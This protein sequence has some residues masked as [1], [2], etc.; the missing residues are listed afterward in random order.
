MTNHHPFLNVFCVWHPGCETADRLVNALY[1]SVSRDVENPV[2]RG[3][4]VPVYFRSHPA[5]SHHGLPLPVDVETAR[6]TAVVMFVDDQ[7]LDAADPIP[8]QP[9]TGWGTYAADLLARCQAGAPAGTHRVYPVSLTANAF[10]LHPAL[11]REN[12]LRLHPYLAD[13][14]LPAR[15]LR[16]V[17]HALC[18]QLD[19]TALGAGRDGDALSPEPVQLFLS[20]AKQD[21]APLAGQLQAWLHANTGL[22]DFFD[23]RDIAT[24]YDFA[25]EIM[26]QIRRSALLAVQTDAYATRTWCRTEV[27]LA[28]RY[29]VPL[30]VVN[31][32]ERGEGRSFPY[33]GNVPTARLRDG[34]DFGEVVLLMLQEV[35]RFRYLR[36]H[37]D[38]LRV[39][40]HLP[41]EAKVFYRAPELLSLV[42]LLA[43]ARQ[44]AAADSQTD[45]PDGKPASLI[46]YSDPPL[47]SEEF[48]L[49]SS[50]VPGTLITT[51]TNLARHGEAGFRPE[52]FK[53]KVIALSISDSPDLLRLGFGKMHLTDAMVEIA[54]YLL[55]R[56][57]TLAYGGDLRP[58]GFTDLLLQL[59]EGYE[60]EAADATAPP[61]TVLPSPRARN[62]LAWPLYVPM[63]PAEK[64]AYRGMVELRPVPPPENVRAALGLDP[65]AFLPPNTP[66]TR[67][68]WACCLTEMRRA[69]TLQVDARIVLGGQVTGFKGKYPGVAEEALMALDAGQPIYLLGAFGGAARAIADALE[70]RDPEA[71]TQA[72]QEKRTD[73]EC[74]FIE[75]YNGT[76]EAHPG[77]GGPVD[78]EAL[79]GALKARS[80]AGLN[81]GLSDEENRRLFVEQDIREV[82]SLLLR[83]LEARW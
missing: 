10:K 20:H 61:P 50:L 19:E 68:A 5:G 7:M 39:A 53:G 16:E 77:L 80:V 41:K 31:A 30:V 38:G 66:A 33:L 64:N 32:V 74:A 28:K 81:N 13:A 6:H 75:H 79:R 43:E 18:R 71:L 29:R 22:K 54:R 3:L 59:I 44:D 35:F 48:G 14:D 27:L 8:G 78:Y 55:A 24:G 34:G 1:T 40:G 51:P 36:G 69:M 82:V 15:F 72:Y 57:A 9:G 49:L 63:T 73:T 60:A 52:S 67:T 58:G 56:G 46:L 62:Y 21:G 37:F 45:K 83:G 26:G 47:G 42:Q 23:A 17:L 25:R 76:V 2:A 65:A 12:F 11:A 70:G 4:G